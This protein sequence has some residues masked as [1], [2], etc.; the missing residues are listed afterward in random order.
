MV[1]PQMVHF[2]TL[3]TKRG[4][5][6]QYKNSRSLADADPESPLGYTKRAAAYVQLK[7]YGDALQDLNTAIEKDPTSTQAYLHR[8][9]IRK[10][11]CQ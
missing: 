8:G 1:Q 11:T 5:T 9:R 2:H 3:A 10:Q 7:K 4:T 6:Y